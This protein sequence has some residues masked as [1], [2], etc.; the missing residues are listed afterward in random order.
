[1]ARGAQAQ[2]HQSN[3]S[4]DAVGSVPAP[5]SNRVV[6]NDANRIASLALTRFATTPV[7]FVKHMTVQL[8]L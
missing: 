5:P 1:M 2:P 4:P 8:P 6:A 3:A 7:H